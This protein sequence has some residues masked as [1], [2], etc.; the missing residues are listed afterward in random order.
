MTH[1][2][3]PAPGGLSG[4]PFSRRIPAVL[5]HATGPS[6]LDVGCT[7]GLQADSPDI[8]GVL[9]L[10]GHLRNTFPDVWGVDL[11]PAKI[12]ALEEAGFT[13]LVAADAQDLDLGRS[14]DS[15]VAGEVIEHVADPGRFL[16]C[17]ARHLKPGGRLV[18]TTPYVFGLPQVLYAWSRY[19]STCS[20]EE[21][22]LWL[23]PTTMT[24]LGRQ[25]G[26][27]VTHWEL[28]EDVSPVPQT[29]LYRMFRA[30]YPVARRLLPLRLRASTMLAV[31]ERSE[32]GYGPSS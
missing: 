15:I 10:H 6:V 16:A 18:V 7:G 11:S 17:L 12:A 13:N 24:E 2:A 23:C 3:R 4:A 5:R 31:L 22:V 19:P 25:A 28:V 14:F 32:P 9:W 29:V 20:N 30:V 8:G 26:L 27:A 21:H 1:T